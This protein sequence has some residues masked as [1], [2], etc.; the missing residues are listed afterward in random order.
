MPALAYSFMQKEKV[1]LIQRKD[2]LKDLMAWFFYLWCMRFDEAKHT[3]KVFSDSKVGY[4]KKYAQRNSVPVTDVLDT[5]DIVERQK[6]MTRA[7]LALK[8][9]S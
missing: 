6:L 4:A 5:I 9:K 7:L 8:N 1:G 3:D 2:A